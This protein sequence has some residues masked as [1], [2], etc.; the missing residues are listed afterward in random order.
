MLLI[1]W[2]TQNTQIHRH[3]ILKF[4]DTEGAVGKLELEANA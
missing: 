3:R 1:M 4:I 2:G